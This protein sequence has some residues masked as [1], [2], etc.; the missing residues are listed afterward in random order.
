M[1]ARLARYTAND[2]YY[3]WA[4]DTYKWLRKVQYIDDEYNV[5]DGGHVENNCT[6]INR[7]QF[8]Y[9][10]GVLLHGA[11]YLYNY[12][13]SR[14]D[15][16]TMST[17]E[18]AYWEAEVQNLLNG[19]MRNFYPDGI[20]KEPACEDV[21]TCTSD[22][23]CF[24]GFVARW[25]AVTSQLAP[26]TRDTVMATLLTSAQAAV[27]TCNGS[28]DVNPNGRMCG[29]KWHE[30]TWDGS[31][32]AG[33][34]MN[35]LS[36]L[37]AL[38]STYNEVTADGGTGGAPITNSTGGTS[39]GDAAAGYGAKPW[40]SVEEPITTADKAGAAILTI[41]VV[42]TFVASSL[43]VSLD[44]TTGSFGNIFAGWKP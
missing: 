20:A 11:A 29:F 14:T 35:V 26:F 27:Q 43:W 39:G 4:T 40:E 41:V 32:G 5:H 2:T 28:P 3:S 37:V 16:E 17:T 44:E 38:L 7:A 33:H 36:T 1:G 24:K 19:T 15:N 30:T 25:M 18:A 13:S 9:N 8:S 21:G 34:Q 22:M 42:G 23:Y 10:S 31:N 6:D 12:T